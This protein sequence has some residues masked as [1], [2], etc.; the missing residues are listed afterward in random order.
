MSFAFVLFTGPEGYILLEWKKCLFFVAATLIWLLVLACG[1][2]FGCG[3]SFAHSSDNIRD[4][5]LLAFIAVCVVSTLRSSG[6]LI[7]PQSDGRYNSLLIYCLYALVILGVAHVGNAEKPLLYAFAIAYSIC[8][9]IAIMQLLGYNPLELFPNHLN[10]YAP[11]VQEMAPFLGTVG[12]IDLFSALHCLGI[13]M[14]AAYLILGRSKSRALFLI[15]LSLGLVCMLRIQVAS[16]MLALLSTAIL[17][18]A[19]LPPLLNRRY[20]WFS[21]INERGRFLVGAVPAAV[22]LIGM[23]AVLRAYPFSSGTLSELHQL[24]NGQVLDEFGSSRIAIWK[25]TMQIIRKYPVW[26]VGAG[27]LG[28]VLTVQ[29]SRYSQSLGFLVEQGVD[30]AHNEYLH[31]MASFGI[32]GFLPLFLLQLRTAFLFFETRAFRRTE[33]IILAC[34]YFCYMVQAFFNIGSCITTPLIC[35]VWGMLLNSFQGSET[36]DA[37]IFS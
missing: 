9:L 7:L 11:F 23:A 10:Y 31:H 13:P 33:C 8:C 1:I 22:L 36:A 32:L 4:F 24:M 12:N 25:N 30:D 35:I 5:L 18:S 14:S 28:N 34:G 6:P 17:F 15:P 16:G 19:V 27:E 37:R 20:G 2:C 29:F 26:G 3:K 21:N